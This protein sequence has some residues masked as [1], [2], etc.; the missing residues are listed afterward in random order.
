MSEINPVVDN[1]VRDEQ[2]RERERHNNRNRDQ[3]P[4]AVVATQDRAT[5]EAV[6]KDTEDAQQQA[7]VEQAEDEAKTAQHEAKAAIER[8]NKMNEEPSRAEARAEKDERPRDI[9]GQVIV[10][11]GDIVVRSGPRNEDMTTTED[12]RLVRHKQMVRGH[13]RNAEPDMT[14]GKGHEDDDANLDPKTG[15]A[16]GHVPEGFQDAPS[17]VSPRNR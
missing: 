2:D 10:Q 16:K 15:L 5:K 17:A 6:P 9:N 14:G 11:P 13:L 12:D 4:A 1:R 7:F 3:H 8:A